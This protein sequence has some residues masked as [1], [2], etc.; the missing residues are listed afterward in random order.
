LDGHALLLEAHSAILMSS[1][2]A[3]IP[4]DFLLKQIENE[5]NAAF[6]S[7]DAARKALNR[8]QPAESRGALESAAETHRRI[9][10]RVA[11]SPVNRVR[12]IAHQLS[13]L[14]EAIDWLSESITSPK[15]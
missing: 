9:S 10:Q 6:V 13:E 11:D 8:R 1:K 14:R 7:L 5:I 2:P 15:K 4:R 12:A 3:S